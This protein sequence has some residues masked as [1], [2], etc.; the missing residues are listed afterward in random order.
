MK[1]VFSF[2]ERFFPSQTFNEAII[3]GLSRQFYG[4]DVAKA[5]L[6]EVLMMQKESQSILQSLPPDDVAFSHFFN[7]EKALRKL[8]LAL[9]MASNEEK[10]LGLLVDDIPAGPMRKE[11]MD[12]C[13]IY[14]IPYIEHVRHGGNFRTDLVLDFTG[15]DLDGTVFNESVE[16]IRAAIEPTTKGGRRPVLALQLMDCYKH[17]Q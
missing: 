1:Q 4:F 12:V 10:R 5:N 17:N 14:E 9:H 2:K 3:T 16:M 11:I 8:A 7:S 6:P 15:K 13:E